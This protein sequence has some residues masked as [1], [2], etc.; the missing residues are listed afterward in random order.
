[1]PVTFQTAFGL[2]NILQL[3]NDK[4]QRMWYYK[5]EHIISAR[6]IWG[7]RNKKEIPN[8]VVAVVSFADIL[9]TPFF[10]S[11]KKGF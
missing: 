10:S 6:F 7:N 5:R 4:Y 11:V 3:L 9:N 1:M 2:Y 8:G